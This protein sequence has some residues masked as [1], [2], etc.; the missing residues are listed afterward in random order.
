MGLNDGTES[1]H[2]LNYVD[3]LEGL[4]PH[5]CQP[6]TPIEWETRN[7]VGKSFTKVTALR[8]ICGKVTEL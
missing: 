6:I 5:Q 3:S 4:E 7:A 8:C 1:I 2:S